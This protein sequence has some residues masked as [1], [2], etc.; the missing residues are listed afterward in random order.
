MPKKKKSA[1][2]RP[3]YNSSPPKPERGSPDPQHS[4]QPGRAAAADSRAP[5]KD[6]PHAHPLAPAHFILREDG[7][8]LDC[9]DTSPLSKAQTCLRT[10]DL[11]F[12]SQNPFVRLYH[13]NFLELLDAISAK[14]PE[15]RFDAIFADPPT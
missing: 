15:G 14:Y 3:L 10:P 8:I 5:S 11:I 2:Q 9:G 7:S 13:G 1:K 4:R 6:F 12:R